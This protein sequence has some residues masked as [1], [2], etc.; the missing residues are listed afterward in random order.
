[1]LVAG[2]SGIIRR[3][4]SVQML[5]I[6]TLQSNHATIGILNYSDVQRFHDP[7]APTDSPD[8]QPA[9]DLIISRHPLQI[10]QTM[11]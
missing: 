1:M 7:H 6:T 5:T 4:P 3:M 9:P 11:L 8:V 2:L 10:D